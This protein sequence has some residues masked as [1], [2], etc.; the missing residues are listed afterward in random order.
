M[1]MTVA[2]HPSSM[3]FLAFVLCQVYYQFTCLPQGLSSSPRVFTML[4]RVVLKFLRTHSVKIAAWIDDFIL[5]ASSASL[6][7]SHASLTLRTFEELGFLPNFGKSHLTP[8]Q[9]LAHLGLV[10]DTV[11]FTVSVPLDKLEEV[12]RLCR[13]ALSGRVSLR[14]LSSIL[15]S[16][17]FFRWGFPHAAVHYRSLQ[18]CVTSFLARGFSYD[19]KVFPSSSARLDLEWWT[20]TGD[21]L[22]ARSLLLL[23]G[24]GG[25]LRLKFYGLGWL[26]LAG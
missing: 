12:Q 24:G 6:V 7:S 21:S 18:R 23:S 20:L 13:L 10:W 22:S 19:T 26:D 16:I 25:F 8:V 17:E 1:P 14:S 4:M 3:P 9:R 2:M 11:D 5:A 15:G